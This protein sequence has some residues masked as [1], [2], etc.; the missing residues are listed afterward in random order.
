[1]QPDD[2]IVIQ[3]LETLFDGGNPMANVF[4]ISIPFVLPNTKFVGFKHVLNF[5]KRHQ[6][7]YEPIYFKLSDND[8]P[9]LMDDALELQLYLTYI[10]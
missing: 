8:T 5:A 10:D 1:M 6:K 3:K 4:S 7:N 9:Q 2:A